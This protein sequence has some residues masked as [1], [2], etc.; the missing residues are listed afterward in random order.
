MPQY[1][2]NP[3]PKSAAY[4]LFHVPYTVLLPDAETLSDVDFMFG[5]SLFKDAKA[6][7]E[8]GAAMVYKSRTVAQMAQHLADGAPIALANPKKA[9]EIHQLIMRHLNDWLHHLEEGIRFNQ[10]IPLEGLS[11]FDKLALHILPIARCHGLN[12]SKPRKSRAHRGRFGMAPMEQHRVLAQ[13]SSAVFNA[14]VEEARALGQR[15]STASSRDAVF[16]EEL[17]GSERKF[18]IW[19]M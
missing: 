19:D 16:D 9:L 7:E 2:G 1:G 14:I 10:K 8:L 17:K 12:D 6:N 4:L 13:H 3:A 11:E 5:M 15:I 18:S